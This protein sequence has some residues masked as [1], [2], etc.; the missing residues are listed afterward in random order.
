MPGL[1]ERAHFLHLN[2]RFLGREN[3]AR[4]PTEE[5]QVQ[6]WQFDQSPQVEEDASQ[7]Q[8]FFTAEPCLSGSPT[9][10]TLPL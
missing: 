5:F 7:A 2:L 3:M 6:G 8:N 1:G 10:Q 9:I 4:P